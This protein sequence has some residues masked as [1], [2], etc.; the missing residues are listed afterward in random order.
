M[1]LCVHYHTENAGTP[2]NRLAAVPEPVAIASP[3]APPGSWLSALDYT[4]CPESDNSS[5]A[6]QRSEYRTC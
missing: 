5:Y 2:G 1:T 3:A 6:A 4:R